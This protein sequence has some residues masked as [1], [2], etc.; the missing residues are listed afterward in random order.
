MISGFHI[1]LRIA[2]RV[3]EVATVVDAKAAKVV[4]A[5]HQQNRTTRD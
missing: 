4:M 1:G 3:V 5:A 2:A